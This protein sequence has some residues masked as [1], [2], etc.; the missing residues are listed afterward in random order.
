MILVANTAD[1]YSTPRPAV[2]SRNW[3]L[4]GLSDGKKAIAYV[5][6]AAL[7][8]FVES[9]TQEGGSCFGTVAVAN[10][11]KCNVTYEG[12]SEDENNQYMSRDG[13]STFTAYIGT[14]TDIWNDDVY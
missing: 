7:K 4:A 5:S 3:G 8:T 9:R 11:I 6:W 13:I 14:S 2:N 12:A 1:S 10:T